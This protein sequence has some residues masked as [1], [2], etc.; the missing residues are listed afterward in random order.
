MQMEISKSSCMLVV[1][2]VGGCRSLGFTTTL[3]RTC[4]DLRKNDKFGDATSSK[5]ILN[6]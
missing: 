1:L 4:S 6:G 3:Y 2:C 5:V